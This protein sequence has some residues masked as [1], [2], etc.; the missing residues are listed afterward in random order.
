[1]ELVPIELAAS[2]PQKLR[3]KGGWGWGARATDLCSF[4]VGEV[5]G[6][7][8]QLGVVNTSSATCDPLLAASTRKPYSLEAV[9]GT[10]QAGDDRLRNVVLIQHRNVARLL[11]SCFC[12]DTLISPRC[13]QGTHSGGRLSYA[14]AMRCSAPRCQWMFTCSN[15]KTEDEE[16]EPQKAA[17]CRRAC[18]SG[19]SRRARTSK[20]D[21]SCSRRR[22]PTFRGL[23]IL[24]P[25]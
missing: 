13:S 1:M 6:G 16:Q 17:R 2:P 25:T 19:R 7:F 11:D 3:E 21:Q 4:A 8:V 20:A 22:R 15:L 14:S 24:S 18:R 12:G 9:C 10:P 23:V 5:E